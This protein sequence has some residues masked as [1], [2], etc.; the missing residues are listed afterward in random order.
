MR[1]VGDNDRGHSRGSCWTW[2]QDI[3]SCGASVSS[4][5]SFI[6]KRAPLYWDPGSVVTESKPWA[7]PDVVLI[8]LLGVG[9]VVQSADAIKAGYL[10]WFTIYTDGMCQR[11]THMN[12]MTQR[13]PTEACITMT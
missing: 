11:N 6:H 7:L 10:V 13:F 5:L 1:P 12:G 8:L 4:V 2:H 3:G 9:L